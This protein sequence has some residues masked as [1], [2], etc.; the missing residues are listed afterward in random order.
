MLRKTQPLSNHDSQSVVTGDSFVRNMKKRPYRILLQLLAVVLTSAS[1]NLT[2]AYAQH[3]DERPIGETATTVSNNLKR[4]CET[5]VDRP[6]NHGSI[7]SSK[8]IDGSTITGSFIGALCQ[9]VYRTGYRSL[10]YG[11]VTVGE[12]TQGATPE[13]T[14]NNAYMKIREALAQSSQFQTGLNK[15][16]NHQ[17]VTQKA[18]QILAEGVMTWVVQT[19]ALEYHR[20]MPPKN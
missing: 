6:E 15:I 10:I 14:R 4:K 5:F 3:G 2:P 12:I 1:L 20:I 13:Q 11:K 16:R 19:Y 17:G 7:Y 9:G 8:K 18:G